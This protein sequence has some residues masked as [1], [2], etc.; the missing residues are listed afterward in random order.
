LNAKRERHINKI[1]TLSSM[2][3]QAQP[4]G[5]EGCSSPPVAPLVAPGDVAA[6]VLAAASR[7]DVWDLAH[8]GI[9][10]RVAG[11]VST[12][13]VRH[14]LGAHGRG[15]SGDVRT[16]YDGGADTTHVYVRMHDT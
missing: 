10:L 16:A 13:Q 3:E 14:D 12:G 4:K 6:T 1:A 11:E 15:G 5:E 8:G 2:N 7:M 9:N